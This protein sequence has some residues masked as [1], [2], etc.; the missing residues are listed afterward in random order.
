MRNFHAHFA[1]IL[2]LLLAGCQPEPPPNVLLISI[3][4][5]RADRL[6]SYGY[7][8]ARTPVLDKL[9][10]SGVRFDDATS[11]ETTATFQGWEF[12]VGDFPLP[13]A[14]RSP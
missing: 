9:A 3:D 5:L 4:A 1:V 2:A 12:N 7:A 8:Q 14:P 13:F 11:P 6:G 10:A